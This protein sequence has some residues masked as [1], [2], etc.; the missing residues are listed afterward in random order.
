MEF[1]VNL[2]LVPVTNEL[3]YEV[4][5]KYNL[6]NA[7]ISSDVDNSTPGLK[8]LYDASRKP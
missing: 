5:Y 2:Q 8:L 4:T 7:V 1:I 6:L 3:E